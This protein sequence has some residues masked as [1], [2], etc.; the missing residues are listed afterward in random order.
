MLFGILSSYRKLWERKRIGLW[1]SAAVLLL[2]VAFDWR[3]IVRNYDIESEQITEPVRFVLITDLHSCRYGEGQ[4]R[5]IEAVRRQEPDA[6]LLGGDIFDDVIDDTNTELF[7]KGISELYP[8]FYVTGNHEYWSGTAGL[9]EKLRILE[10]YDVRI[11]SGDCEAL[12]VDKQTVNICGVDDPAAFLEDTNGFTRQL[13]AVD[14]AAQNGNFSILLSHRPEYWEEYQQYEFDLVLCGHAHGGQWRIPGLLNGLFAPDQGLFPR[15]A[16][17]L[18]EGR[19]MS[20]IVSRG[21]ARES[22][23]IPR[24]FNRPELVVIDIH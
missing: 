23:R 17:G 21:L 13:D 8:C 11:L 15:C 5:L 4:K 18:Y 16:G 10:Q 7:L 24:I 3:M 2:F 14:K 20:M 9:T 6:V 22:T 1:L 12:Q 19:G